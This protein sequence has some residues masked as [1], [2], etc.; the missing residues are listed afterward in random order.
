MSVAEITSIDALDL[1]RRQ[2]VVVERL[3]R[4]TERPL[5]TPAAKSASVELPT[6]GA[7]QILEALSRR[8][9][10]GVAAQELGISHAAV[11]QAVSRLEHRYALQLFTKAGWGLEATPGCEALIQAYLSATSTLRRALAEAAHEGRRHAVIPLGAWRWLSPAM[12]RLRHS[13]PDVSIRTFQDADDLA[14]A[15]FAI[16]PDEHLPAAGFDSTALY[17]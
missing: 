17:D 1:R 3:R 7:L 8:R 6:L 15:D 12:F 2:P 11:S 9:R 10:V 5:R 13:F 16:L 4:P 14:T